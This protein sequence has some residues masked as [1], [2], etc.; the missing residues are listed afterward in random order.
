MSVKIS[1]I[2]FTESF[3][4]LSYIIYLTYFI[5]LSSFYAEN[6]EFAIYG[7]KILCILL[8]IFNEIIN[9][10]TKKAVIGIAMVIFFSVMSFI[11]D[12]SDIAFV[13]VYLYC[14][15]NISFDK[16]AKI[17][18]SIT[19]AA[20]LIIIISSYIG[21]IPN[22]S[23]IRGSDE[24][25]YLGF[26]YVL[27]APMYLFNITAIT[28]YLNK[29]KIKFK[30]IGVLLITNFI[31]Y[32]L[33]KARLSVGLS[34][35]L[36]LFTIVLKEKP[37]FLK[38]KHLVCYIMISL[39]ALSFIASI[40]LTIQY[41][42][43]VSWQRNL[44]T[45]MGDRLQLGK[46]ALMNYAVGLLG[47]KVQLFGHGLDINGQHTLE[48]YSYVDNL[49]VQVMIRYGILFL[50]LYIIVNTIVMYQCYKKQNYHLLLIMAILALRGIVDD[51]SL[52][53]Y[54]NS[55]WF[56]IGAMLLSARSNVKE[57]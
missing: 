18:R 47:Q 22:V 9:K 24:R 36:I 42:A 10:M 15:R 17:T 1:K 12:A 49:Y 40:I 28:V 5:F 4:F 3:F 29:H 14:A 30:T 20:L 23:A 38:N 32:N 51:L 6:I 31:M 39:F 46:N 56:I 52:L 37:N 57:T 41:D 33:T 53:L 54:Y 50:L 48:V 11:I 7:V 19:I 55:F 44:N 26:R 45:M 25:W 21:I 16:I 35:L 13:L 27:Y 43:N 2:K 34:I 8:L